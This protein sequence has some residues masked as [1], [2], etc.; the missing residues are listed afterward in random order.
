MVGIHWKV[1]TE[2]SQM[3]THVPGFQ[4]FFIGFC[5]FFVLAS[6][7]IFKDQLRQ[8]KSLFSIVGKPYYLTWWLIS[9]LNPRSIDQCEIMANLVWFVTPV[10][11]KQ[12]TTG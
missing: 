1:L 7:I 4:S 2:H 5:I 10:F 12:Q 6:S 11:L 3:N 9:E 8:E